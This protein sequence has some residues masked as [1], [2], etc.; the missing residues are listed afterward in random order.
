M[1]R[2]QTTYRIQLDGMSFLFLCL[3]SEKSLCQTIDTLLT[4]VDELPQFPGGVVKLTEYVNKS[5][6]KNIKRTILKNR[7][8]SIVFGPCIVS[9]VIEKDGS[10]SNIVLERSTDSLIAIEVHRIISLM[11][12]WQP[13]MK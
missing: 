8:R 5:I 1:V 12:K 11:P 4:R 9:F 10:V 7:A 13:E 2:L 3:R 6:S